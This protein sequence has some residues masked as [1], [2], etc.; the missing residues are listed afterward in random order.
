MEAMTPENSILSE[1]LAHISWA[2]RSNL[3][4]FLQWSVSTRL[5]RHFVPFHRIFPLSFYSNRRFT[6]SSHQKQRSRARLIWSTFY[7]FIF[8]V[9]KLSTSTAFLLFVLGSMPTHFLLQQLASR[10]N[11][12]STWT[13]P[14]AWS[15]LNQQQWHRPNTQPSYRFPHCPPVPALIPVLH[16][17]ESSPL[18]NCEMKWS[19]VLKY[20][21]IV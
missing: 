21:V 7:N 9:A 3:H 5:F 12:N 4:S 6:T 16:L 18:T 10:L 8:Y 20:T 1:I 11:K 14:D 15:K 17:D 13:D 19:A 2:R